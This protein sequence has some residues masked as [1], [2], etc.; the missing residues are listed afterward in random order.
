V[1]VI[2]L[3]SSSVKAD[4]V[5]KCVRSGMFAMTWDDGPADFSSQLLDILGK[6]N[7]KITFHLS[8]QHLT[9]PNVQS[10]VQRIS[11]EGHLIG[12]RTEPDW[13]LFQMSDDMIK[14]VIARAGNT[15]ANFSRHYP[16]FVRLPYKGWDARVLRAVEATGAIITMHNIESYDYTGNSDRIYNSF[17]LSVSLKTPGSGSFISVQ[18]DSI[19][20]SVGV[21]GKLIDLIKE[22][23]YE[24]VTLDKCLGLGDMTKNKEPLK[25]ADGVKLPPMPGDGA[26][27]GASKGGAAGGAGGM[28]SGSPFSGGKMGKAGAN[29]ATSLSANRVLMALAL[30]VAVLMA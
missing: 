28:E 10:M 18:R 29:A 3:F 27:G 12:L 4:I 19:Q 7:V 2:A 22:N 20:G 15:L 1:S 24:I 11:S 17:Q 13:N 9:D 21:T 14:A 25:G 5:S 6:K 26:T 8:T 30:V 23:G 16:K